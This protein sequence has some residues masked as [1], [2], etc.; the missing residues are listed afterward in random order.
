MKIA[1]L[2]DDPK[3][4]ERFKEEWSIVTI[5]K[6]S[7]TLTP[8]EV[9]CCQDVNDFLSLPLEEFDLICLDH[10]LGDFGK[11][12]YPT[13]YG[14]TIE[15]DGQFAANQIRHRSLPHIII[16]SWNPTGALRMLR[17]LEEHNQVSVI[18]FGDKLFE[19]VKIK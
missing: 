12:A 6:K 3:R 5:D 18:Q 4:I 9:V 13:T 17:I 2:D 10:D 14:G 15:L 8:V 7:A 16:H 11:N 19:M 1:I